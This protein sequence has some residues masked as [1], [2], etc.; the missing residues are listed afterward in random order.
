MRFH[1]LD[2]DVGYS[3]VKEPDVEW[4]T[5]LDWRLSDRLTGSGGLAVYSENRTLAH[6]FLLRLGVRF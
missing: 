2:V 5:T 6:T 3:L 4:G 1:V